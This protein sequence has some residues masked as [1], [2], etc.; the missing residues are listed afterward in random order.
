MNQL[1]YPFSDLSN[2]DVVIVHEYSQIQNQDYVFV[3]KNNQDFGKFF[4]DILDNNISTTG[5]HGSLNGTLRIKILPGDYT[6][7][8]T[9]DLRKLNGIS[10]IVF[11][12]TPFTNLICNVPSNGSSIYLGNVASYVYFVNINISL[13][14]SCYFMNH[15][16]T[17]TDLYNTSNGNYVIF[18]KCN[19]EY[20]K[21]FINIVTLKSATEL[22]SL[23]IFEFN[24]CNITELRTSAYFINWDAKLDSIITLHDCKFYTGCKVKLVSSSAAYNSGINLQISYNTALSGCIIEVDLTGVIDALYCFEN[25]NISMKMTPELTQGEYEIYN[26]YMTMLEIGCTFSNLLEVSK[27]LISNNSIYDSMKVGIDSVAADLSARNIMIVNNIV[28]SGNITP[29]IF[30][31]AKKYKFFATGNIG[32][33]TTS[34]YYERNE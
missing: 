34:T 2:V 30:D 24:H 11:I 27:L 7:K 25:R 3:Y 20:D 33:N 6:V 17:I 29:N 16:D 1:T 15:D 13:K 5:L 22:G 21:T 14:S 32:K 8:T 19:I 9:I 4:N 18:Y 12:G 28:L 10:E 26:N 31:M 23:P